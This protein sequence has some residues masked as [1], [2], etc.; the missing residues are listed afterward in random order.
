MS[1]VGT[2][3]EFSDT[4]STFGEF[5]D[6]KRKNTH[7]ACGGASAGAGCFTAGVAEGYLHR[8]LVNT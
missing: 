7:G 4:I 6:I 3:R 1:R 2:F 8:C 5:S